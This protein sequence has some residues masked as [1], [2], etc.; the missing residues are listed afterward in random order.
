MPNHDEPNIRKIRIK[1]KQQDT[2]DF[3]HQIYET[4]K[5]NLSHFPW[6]RQAFKIIPWMELFID[7]PQSLMISFFYFELNHLNVIKDVVLCGGSS[8]LM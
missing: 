8:L 6:R 1:K 3:L 5:S 2:L 7:L 4:S